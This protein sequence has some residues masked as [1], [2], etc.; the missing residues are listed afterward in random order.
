MWRWIFSAAVL[1]GL[2]SGPDVLDSAAASV[3]PIGWREV[4]FAFLGSLI[5][6]VFVVGLQLLRAAPTPSRWALRFFGPVSASLAASGVSAAAV[7]LVT[8]GVVP[9]AFLFLALG[10]GLSL[11]V[12]AC[13]AI[14][15]RKFRGVA[16]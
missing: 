10:A 1:L 12:F 9:H 5:A 3:P 16:L 2:A 11:G 8:L 7:G 14:F 13:H 6:V 15:R 4:P